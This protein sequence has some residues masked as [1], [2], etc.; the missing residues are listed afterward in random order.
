MDLGYHGGLKKDN[1]G[2]DLK[3]L[4]IGS[5]GTLGIITR[6]A[7]ACP[8]R[9]KAVNVSFLGLNCF[10]DVIETFKYARADLGEI[11]SSCEFIDA[12]SLDSVQMNLGLN[13]PLRGGFPFYMLIETSGS[14][15]SHDKKSYH[16]F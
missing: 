13:S 6:I 11:L 7:L 9:P 1:T 12:E 4:F 3:H 8:S 10:S 5:E 2:Y 15:K 16:N 14:N